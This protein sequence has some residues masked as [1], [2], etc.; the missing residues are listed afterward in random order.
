MALRLQNATLTWI[1]QITSCMPALLQD[2]MVSPLTKRLQNNAS[3]KFNE[4]RAYSALSPRGNN[5]FGDKLCSTVDIQV[6]Y[7]ADC[8][9]LPINIQHAQASNNG[10]GIL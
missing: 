5:I 6:S 10:P 8:R 4:I 3:T 7:C 1:M 9:A 2:V